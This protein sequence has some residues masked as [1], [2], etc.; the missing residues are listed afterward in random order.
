METRAL[1]MV[2]ANV[3]VESSDLMTALSSSDSDLDD[4]LEA[5]ESQASGLR[6]LRK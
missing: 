1:S 3:C 5:L 6:T 4:H 2:L